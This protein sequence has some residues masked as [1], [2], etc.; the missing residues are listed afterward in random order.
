MRF[1]VAWVI[2]RFLLVASLFGAVFAEEGHFGRHFPHGADAVDYLYGPD[3]MWKDQRGMSFL[4]NYY[5]HCATA[6]RPAEP[7]VLRDIGQSIKLTA[8]DANCLLLG[9]AD[10]DGEIDDDAPS[11]HAFHE[12]AGRGIGGEQR[13]GPFYGFW[14]DDNWLARYVA[15]AYDRPQPVGLHD[16]GY[17]LRWR[18]LGGD[19]AGAML[20]ESP[21]H[22]DQLAL[23][24]LYK[25]HSGDIAGALA[26]WR[27]I[28]RAS[29]A[30]YDRAG[31]RLQYPGIRE[32]Y[33]LGLWGILTERLLASGTF[34]ERQNLVQHS[35]AI[36]SDLLSLQE[37]DASGRRLGWITGIGDP[38]TL[39]NTETLSVAVLAL[40]AEAMWV[41]EPGH[42]PLR[43]GAGNYLYRSQHVLSAVRKL[44]WPGHMVYGPYWAI[45]PGVYHVDFALRTPARGAFEATLATLDVYDGRSI[46]SH[47][48]ITQSMM[49][50]NDQ[51]LRYRLRVDV[52]EPSSAIEFRVYWHG[53]A[54]L[55][56]GPIR[57]SRADRGDLTNTPSG[58]ARP[59][60]YSPSLD[61]LSHQS[62]YSFWL[63]T[64]IRAWYQQHSVSRAFDRW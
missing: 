48:D 54:D 7:R 39:M 45:E 17:V 23:N 8:P 14:F 25:L 47:A 18:A 16:K 41:F 36:R 6:D 58:S 32:T 57:V 13:T 29:G 19:N 5:S 34:P 3:G 51:W 40:G 12:H 15:I 30:S 56:V 33:H 35:I 2:A 53:T 55:D 4:W 60:G 62:V 24:G 43:T 50:T 42:E 44:S 64:L 46:L 52:E 37:R 38:R 20:Y 11:G 49:P 27:A 61:G 9:D 59:G 26:D 21:Q 28:E 1:H 22:V 10:N 31:R 63:Y